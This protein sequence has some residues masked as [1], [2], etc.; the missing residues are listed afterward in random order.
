[1]NEKSDSLSYRE[2]FF[3]IT[4]AFLSGAAGLS[5]EVLY[6]R[7]LS[8]YFG[9]VYF[10]IAAILM[11]T[12]LGL[13]VGYLLAHLLVAYLWAV[14]G[15]LGL[16]A[17]A[18]AYIFY[19]FGL[20]PTRFLAYSNISSMIW[21]CI[22]AFIPFFLTGIS[23]PAFAFM[24][25]EAHKKSTSHIHIE[26][27]FTIVYVT[28]NVGAAIV[29]LLAE[30]F[31]IR[32]YGISASIVAFA[33]VNLVISPFLFPL[34]RR[35]ASSAYESSQ[36]RFGNFS[37]ALALLVI[38][39]ASTIYQL[40][41]L[42]YCWRLFGPTPMVFAV[43]LFSALIGIVIGS[44]LSRWLISLQFIVSLLAIF[45]PLLFLFTEPLIN[46]WSYIGNSAQSATIFSFYKNSLIALF[47]L[48][49]FILF[50]A[51]I[52]LGVRAASSASYGHILATV[53]LGNALGVLALLVFLKDTLNF[54]GIVLV[55]VGLL[56]FAGLVLNRKSF[57]KWRREWFISTACVICCLIFFFSYPHKLSLIGSD[58]M[59]F[60]KEWRDGMLNDLD[61]I[62]EIKQNSDSAVIYHWKDGLRGL[63]HLG[64]TPFHKFTVATI[65]GQ[66]SLSVLPSLYS[67][68]HNN[69]FVLGLAGGLAPTDMA[70]R[71]NNV[72]VI[73]INPAMLK[74]SKILARENGNLLDKK[75]VTIYI[76][77]GIVEL[78][79]TKKK[80]DL[81]LNSLSPPNYYSANKL[82]TK[83]FFEMAKQS[84]SPGGV[85]AG[86]I[87]MY[88]NY[89]AEDVLMHLDT[90]N[91]VFSQCH[92]YVIT[93]KYFGYVCGENLIRR[94]P[95]VDDYLGQWL[96][97]L[98]M[99][100][101]EEDFRRVSTSKVMVNTL[102]H[103]VLSF[104]E[105]NFRIKES[106]LDKVTANWG[107]L[108]S[109]QY[110]RGNH[111]CCQQA[112]SY[113][114]CEPLF[115]LSNNL[116]YYCKEFTTER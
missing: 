57:L 72:S 63:M 106:D 96:S 32:A 103:P 46:A 39:F 47:G 71:Y 15:L 8:V 73:D 66:K 41:Y 115:A 16:Y 44:V 114:I 70:D 67:R 102:D 56:L 48:P 37:L 100:T 108:R 104:K 14:E 94:E 110:Q 2:R 85:Y 35:F 88:L 5:Y 92:Y 55:L 79:R 111:I 50:G 53:S 90:L 26:K 18:T 21:V 13:A 52:P 98:Q 59:L 68:Q 6:A 113:K 49:I 11:S 97:Q 107:L 101:F 17:L 33:C 10:I 105:L 62:Q 19:N 89:T 86:W 82:Y 74:V 28:Y 84:L 93:W 40:S 24:L 112:S 38:G 65:H 34:C 109:P 77:D 30:F 75:N 23:V 60:S 64:Y 87:Y 95:T 80:Y 29:V 99:K 78:A 22:V 20:E 91:S 61:R 69:A 43:V 25:R 76:Q 31:L 58:V 9:D 1:M 116:K 42:E 4:L 51:S 54:I 81:F 36:T 45:I 12:F 7:V 3:L 83:E 27:P